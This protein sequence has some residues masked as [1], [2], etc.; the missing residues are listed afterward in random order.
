MIFLLFRCV[1]FF[2]WWWGG[3][4]FWGGGQAWSSWTQTRVVLLTLHRNWTRQR[5]TVTGAKEQVHIDLHCLIASHIMSVCVSQTSVVSLFKH[6]PLLLR[7]SAGSPVW[8][9]WNALGC[10][11]KREW[12]EALLTTKLVNHQ[13]LILE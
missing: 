7:V 3:C 8:P 13:A 1:Q 9:P 11:R 4:I 6:S 2:F 5:H 12:L 10:K